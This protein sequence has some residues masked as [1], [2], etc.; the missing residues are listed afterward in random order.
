M[1]TRSLLSFL[2]WLLVFGIANADGVNPDEPFEYVPFQ[3]GNKIYPEISLVA[4]YGGSSTDSFEFTYDVFFQMHSEQNFFTLSLLTEA[5][6]IDGQSTGGCKV[7]RFPRELIQEGIP[8]S[9]SVITDR[10][11]S[12]SPGTTLEGTRVQ[13]LGLPGVVETY[14]RG[15]VPPPKGQQVVLPP[16][17]P[18]TYFN[19]RT[20]VVT[21]GPVKRP[22]NLTPQLHA[23]YLYTE[24]EKALEHNWIVASDGVLSGL[25]S[26]RS[27]QGSA[28]IEAA[29][30]VL[31]L[32]DQKRGDTV[33]EEGYFLIKP[34]L[35]KLLHDL[36]YVPSSE[37]TWFAAQD[38][39]L[40]LRNDSINDGA[41][42]L[43]TLEKIQG[44]ATRSAIGFDLSQLDTNTLFRATLKLTIDPNSQVTGWGNGKNIKLRAVTTDWVEGNGVYFG[45]KKKDQM[46]GDGTGATWFAPQANAG[47]WNGALDGSIASTSAPVII[48]N[49][50]QG[51]VEFDVT[52][53][54]QNPSISGWLILKED[55][56]LGAKVSF[57][58][59]EGA[60]QLGDP[61]L[62]PQLFL[63]YGGA[64]SHNGLWDV[65]GNLEQRL[66]SSLSFLLATL[67]NRSSSL[68]ARTPENELSWSF[69]ES[70]LALA[71]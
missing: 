64:V 63:E 26:V 12:Y 62:G 36:G 60:S 56:N 30:E 17:E 39:I 70:P 42:P 68:S 32:L 41:N 59:R 67:T 21:V 52:E 35:D 40:S 24:A 43:L 18:V 47:G 49:H 69:S 15:D 13:S 8:P 66:K 20:L 2:I 58:S 7:K 23:D 37:E 28:Q 38:T 34:N 11:F 57:Y 46:P 1:R 71:E 65:S 61:G 44:K 9:I 51:T 55:E 16:T 19:S 10:D 4:R 50:L 6:L 53:D 54:V 14:T 29:L 5:D 25:S 48:T 31:K 3:V 33:S 22:D 45:L 27:S